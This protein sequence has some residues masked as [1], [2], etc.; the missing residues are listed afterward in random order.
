ML[1]FQ[2]GEF[3]FVFLKEAKDLALIPDNIY[4]VTLAVIALTMISTPL[5]ATQAER[6]SAGSATLFGLSI[7]EMQPE[8]QELTANL[9]GHV[10]IA[11]YGLSGRNVGQVLRRV[12]IPHLYVELKAENVNKVRREGEFIV[13]GD[14]ASNE[15]LHTLGVER[16]NA[17]VL[18]INDP[19][20]LARTISIARQSNPDLY[21]LART[22]YV[23]E[24]EH[25]CQLGADE[26]VPDEF[27]ASLQLG[28][29]L[30]RRFKR[31]EG[32][33]LHVLSELRQKHYTS[34]VHTDCPRTT[35]CQFLKVVNLTT[36]RFQMIR[37]TSEPALP[38]L[39]CASLPV[40]P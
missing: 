26:V 1:L 25:L 30:M 5:I 2:A 10:L 22:R 27:E 39:T 29:N 9:S 33:I 32:R 17:L 31:N 16:A 8:A 6:R 4:Q 40:S 12:D 34:M 24:L 11:G 18:A 13:Y 36:R 21:I 14:I 23:A 37:L 20:A 19:A 15:V 7:K 28:A 38:R 3:S 35:A